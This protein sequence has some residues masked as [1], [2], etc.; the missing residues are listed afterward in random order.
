MPEKWFVKKEDLITVQQ[1]P[2]LTRRTMSFINDIMMCLF[3][4]ETGTKVDLHTHEAVQNG[5]V[6][7][8][9]LKFFKADGSFV[10]AAAGDSY[11]F[12]SNEP[13]GSECLEHAVFVEN[14]T[15]AR[16]EYM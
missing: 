6:L 14:F 13:H 12:S 4:Q 2:G 16:K 3:E 8:G 11:A 5:Y 7:E 1:K 15:P 9:K 10:V